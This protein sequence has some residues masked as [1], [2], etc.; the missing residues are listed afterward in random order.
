MNPVDPHIVWMAN[1]LW[2]EPG[3]D[4]RMTKEMERYANILWVDPPVSLMT[5]AQR[6]FDRP[7]T[8]R[9]MLSVLNDRVTRLTP[10]A[11]PGM[12]RFG[13]RVST[14][15]L[16]RAQV[17][18]A[19]H[20]IGIE[21]VAVVATNLEGVLGRWGNGVVRALHGTDDYVAGAGLMGLSASRLRTQERKAVAQADVVTALSPL[22]AERW[23]ALRGGAV[24]L[25][26]NGCT[27]P[28]ATG[29]VPKGVRRLPR[30]VVGLVGRLNARID[31]DLVEAVANARFSLLIVG[32]RDSRWES[33]R[34]SAL[35]ARPQVHY[36]GRVPEEE[37]ASY[38]AAIDIGITPYLD[39]PFNRAS[40]PLKTLDY[41]SVGR[42][43]VSTT[44]PASL[45]L[46]NDLCQSNQ[47]A[48]A[49][50]IITLAD[51]RASFISAVQRIVGEPG[52][53]NQV[54]DGLPGREP[55]Y[56]DQCREFAMRHSW[57][58]RA[59][60]LAAAIGLVPM[61]SS[62]HVA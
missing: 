27:I 12:T 48:F 21:P 4:R 40:F 1:K 41:L 50:Q 17:R 8:V 13:I 14:A 18:W 55:I 51:D 33:S 10:T 6:R 54:A 32:P 28:I 44:L 34:F 15:L 46:N 49:N 43:V 16:I 53:P 61:L 19:L 56:A 24:T 30:P 5:S 31:I 20:R 52:K 39:S 62:L 47:A 36:V 38:I 25:I 35:V 3:I 29:P 37:V 11:L 7:R 23:S 45:W 42:P 22:L 9:P 26:P 59:E 2:E 58:S 57:N 60:T